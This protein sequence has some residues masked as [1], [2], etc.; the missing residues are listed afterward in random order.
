MRNFDL[1]NLFSILNRPDG[2]PPSQSQDL[3]DFYRKT[4]PKC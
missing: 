2:L 4:L 1:L 3:F